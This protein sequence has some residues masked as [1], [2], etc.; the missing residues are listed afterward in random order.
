MIL[1]SFFTHHPALCSFILFHCVFQVYTVYER[2]VCDAVIPIFL[3]FMEFW[4][5]LEQHKPKVFSQGLME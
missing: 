2:I 4:N 1:A 3:I 5:S